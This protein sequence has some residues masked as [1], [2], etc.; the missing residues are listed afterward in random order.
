MPFDHEKLKQPI[1]R[2]DV[3]ALLL[4]VMGALQASRTAIRAV[5]KGQDPKNDI[6]DLTKQIDDLIQEWEE[7]CGWGDDQ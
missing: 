6:A 7:F 2:L 1:S 4:P 5:S 3:A